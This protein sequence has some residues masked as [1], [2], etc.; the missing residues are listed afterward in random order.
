VERIQS[1]R[2]SVTDED[3]LGC[4]TTNSIVKQVNAL[5]QE[6]IWITVTDIGDKLDISCGFAYSSI[7]EDLGYHEMCAR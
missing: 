4:L 3:C 6:D 1:G 5:V 7:H 2:T